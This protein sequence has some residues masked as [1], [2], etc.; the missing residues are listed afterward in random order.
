LEAEESTLE[1]VVVIIDNTD[2]KNTFNIILEKDLNYII[3]N[4]KYDLNFLSNK[5]ILY[6]GGGGFLGYYFT[7]ALEKWNSNINNKKI[8][9]T[10]LD[11]F[12]IRKPKW[13]KK[14]KDKNIFIIKNNINN[15]KDSFF[16][17]FDIIIHGAS[18]ASPTYYRKFPIETMEANVMG[19]WKILNS[20][21]KSSIQK[22]KKKVLFFFSS[23]E[24][25]G[26]PPAKFIPTD[27]NYNGNVSFTGPRSC[28]DESKRFGETL[29][30]NYA[31]KFK[32]KA[33][34]ARPFNNYGPGMSINDKR[35]IP[36]LIQNI[37]KNKNMH[38]YS[39]G[40]PTRTFCYVADAIIGYLKLLAKGKNLSSYNIGSDKN[41]ISVYN[42]ARILRSI[43]SKMINYRGRIIK[44]ISNDKNYLNDNPNR[45]KP[46]IKKSYNDLNFKSKILLKTG[47]YNTLMYF[48]NYKD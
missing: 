15:F 48:L 37:L 21:R 17:K 32:F 7:L 46:D 22:N 13:L 23:S 3:N 34:I 43:S 31:K 33:K 30:L 19:L 14:I 20:Y 5:K 38:I 16:N 11:N 8:Y 39:N 45:R 47:L 18:I 4:C 40:K 10:I 29:I 26:D 6:T 35:L 24:V 12:L 42:L 25:Y 28:Y 9:F 27:E 36:D 41:E 2:M 1:S 44:K